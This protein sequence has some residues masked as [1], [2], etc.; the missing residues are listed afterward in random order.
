VLSG[1]KFHYPV[2]QPELPAPAELNWRVALMEKALASLE[3]E[4][5]EPKTF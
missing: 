5:K 1:N 3:T 2:G 4:V